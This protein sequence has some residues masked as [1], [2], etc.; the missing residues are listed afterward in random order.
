MSYLQQMAALRQRYLQG[1][2]IIQY[3]KS[4]AQRT[5][6][7]VSDILVSYDLQAGSYIQYAARQPEIKAAYAAALADVLN[8]LLQTGQVRRLLDAGVGEATSLAPLLGQLVTLPDT[9]WAFD[10]SWSRLKHAQ[11]YLAQNPAVPPVSLCTGN[12]AQPPFVDNSFDLVMT[13]HALEPNGGQESV[14]LQALYRLTRKYLVLFEP[15]Y[16]LASEAARSRMLSHG[17]V[18]RLYA[19]ACEL[20]YSVLQHHLLPCDNGNPLNPTAVLVIEKP[21]ETPLAET[22]LA[23]P[24]TQTPLVQQDA[25]CFSPEA[26]L[27]Y[28]VIKGIPCLLPENAVVATHFAD[29]D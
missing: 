27:A 9:I 14:L 29:F 4:E 21:G 19:A 1:E 13:S 3:L 15:G 6:N 7:Q 22:M 10:L 8:P 28:P 12:L 24:H 16:E 25:V 20:G 18:T 23:C 17:Y 5:Q 26:L 11:R 2:N